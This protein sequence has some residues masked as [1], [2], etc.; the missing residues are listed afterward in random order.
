MKELVEKKKI[1]FKTLLAEAFAKIK[2]YSS[3]IESVVFSKVMFSLL[4]LS[5]LYPNPKI[6]LF[7]IEIPIKTHI[8]IAK[9]K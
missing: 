2:R 7:A 1:I 8:L 4:V 5:F 9:E 3:Y 6:V